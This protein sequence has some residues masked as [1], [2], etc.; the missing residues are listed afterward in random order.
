MLFNS[1]FQTPKSKGLLAAA[2]GAFALVAMSGTSNALILS[3]TS[4]PNAHIDGNLLTPYEDTISLTG[5]T[6]VTG[7][8]LT[9]D[10]TKCA[11]VLT[12]STCTSSDFDPNP[13]NNEIKFELE[14]DGTTV[15]LL[16]FYT[17]AVSPVSNG[18]QRVEVTFD[19]AAS[20]L[21]ASTNGGIPEDGTFQPLEALAGFL[22]GTAAGDWTLI[23]TDFGTF[24]PLWLTSWTIEVETDGPIVTPPPPPP[25]PAAVSEP[26][27]L[28]ILGL[29]IIGLGIAR[30]KRNK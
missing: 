21:I 8:T 20:D 28:A 3:G 27:T 7:L 15:L 16:D 13:Y 24:D 29:G 18:G 25:P 22:G 14:H 17:Y 12:S 26:G 1:I 2:A 5:G 19:D 9:I 30:R 11:D 6:T 23:A 10:F 4:T